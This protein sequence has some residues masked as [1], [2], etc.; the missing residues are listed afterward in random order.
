MLSSIWTSIAFTIRARFH[1]Q[2]RSHVPIKAAKGNRF[3][4]ISQILG[5]QKARFMTED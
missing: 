3:F 4:S 5:I 1:P 2:Q